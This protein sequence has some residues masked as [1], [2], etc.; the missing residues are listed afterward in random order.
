MAQKNFTSAQVGKV[1][2]KAWLDEAFKSKLEQD[3]TAARGGWVLLAGAGRN[4][5]LPSVR[6][7]LP[8]VTS[9]AR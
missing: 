2:A 3:P 6:G 8:A 9:R 7:L 1:I 4:R 5:E